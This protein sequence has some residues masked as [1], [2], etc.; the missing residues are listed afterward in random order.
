MDNSLA[1]FGCDLFVCLFV[2][3]FL[4]QSSTLLNNKKAGELH[5]FFSIFFCLYTLGIMGKKI[6]YNEFSFGVVYTP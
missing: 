4:G 1:S 6:E 3:L 5:L 2:C